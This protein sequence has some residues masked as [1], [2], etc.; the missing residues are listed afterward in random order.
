MSFIFCN[1][2]LTFFS[3]SLA[4]FSEPIIHV[5]HFLQL[6]FDFLFSF[7]RQLL[8]FLLLHHLGLQH[9]LFFLLFRELGFQQVC[10]ALFFSALICHLCC[11][12]PFLCKCCKMFFSCL[13]SDF[14]NCIFFFFLQAFFLFCPLLLFLTHHLFDVLLGLHLGHRSHCFLDFAPQRRS[15]KQWLRWPRWRPRRTSKR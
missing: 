8:G 5:F 4:L 6:F 7:A 1:S 3:A 11:F 9:F 14:G 15:R 10:S 13:S 12:R 2:S